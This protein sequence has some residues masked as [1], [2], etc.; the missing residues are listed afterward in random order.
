MEL[1]VISGLLMG[2]VLALVFLASTLYAFH[3][4]ERR[5]AALRAQARK[6]VERGMSKMEHVA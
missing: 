5:R 6:N 4:E 3:R 1:S 2:V